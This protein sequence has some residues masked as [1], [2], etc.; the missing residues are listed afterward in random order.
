MS[1]S[2]KG[3]VL[4][5]DSFNDEN[6]VISNDNSNYD[7][8]KSFTPNDSKIQKLRIS[9]NLSKTSSPRG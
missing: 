5:R 3:S 9:K 6:G 4:E 1:T 7:E 2:R 8:N